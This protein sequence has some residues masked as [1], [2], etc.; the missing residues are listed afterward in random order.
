MEIIKG[1]REHTGAVAELWNA[2]AQDPASWWYGSPTKN[3]DEIVDLLQQG[4]CAD[5]ACRRKTP[6]GPIV[7]SRPSTAPD[8]FHQGG[9]APSVSW[10]RVT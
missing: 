7:V 3:I 10:K 6:S 4:G 1:S 2:K 8:A 9:Q 5:I